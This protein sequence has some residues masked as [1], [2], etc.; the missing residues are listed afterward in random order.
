MLLPPQKN[1]KNPKDFLTKK[2]QV[3][4]SCFISRNSYT[5][6]LS[7]FAHYLCYTGFFVHFLSQLSAEPPHSSLSS[8]TFQPSDSAAAVR[9]QMWTDRSPDLS[10]MAERV[11]L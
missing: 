10:V 5:L 2:T 11:V 8:L 3:P 1:A 9:P 6:L 7:E 4:R